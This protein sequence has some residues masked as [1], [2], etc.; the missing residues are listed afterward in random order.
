M[1]SSTVTPR[2]R[3]LRAFF[4]LEA[5][6]GIVLLAC[7]VA[8]LAWANSPWAPAYGALK[9]F[10][11][12]GATGFSFELFVN[13]VLMA[14]FFLL[15]G[16]EIKRELLEGELSSRQ[17]AALPLAGALGGMLLPAL[18]FTAFNRGEPGAGAWGVPMATD[19]AF[20][21]AVML[22]L[23]RRAP[24]GLKVFLVAL[25]IIDDLGAILVIALFYGGEPRVEWLLGAAAVTGLLAGLNRRGVMHPAPYLI[26]GA[27]LWSA[28]FFSGVHAT[29]AG[30]I[31][32]LCIPL[33]AHA[34][35]PRAQPLLKRLEAALHPWV[36]YSVLPLFAL[37]NAGVALSP[38]VVHALREP[39]G[40][41]IM[42]GLLIGKPV[43]ITLFAWLAVRSGLAALPAGVSWAGIWGAGMLGGIG[44]T[45][46]LFIAGLGLAPGLL[47]GAKLAVLAASLVAG[48]S[49]YLILRLQ[50]APPRRATR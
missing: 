6:S 39:L 4:H 5:A 27:L 18:L 49:G 38:H 13:D 23:G 44:F 11:L 28:L 35:A 1:A 14:V 9:H 15:V 3:G 48:V 8:A 20:A 2:P 22:L 16:L 25:A 42:A 31:L 21:L 43:G 41:G 10:A 24:V 46:S 19:I 36:N 45:M 30:V 37:V 47:D 29:L 34:R 50:S 17:R 40:L 26:G 7:A 32:A 33:R 12:P